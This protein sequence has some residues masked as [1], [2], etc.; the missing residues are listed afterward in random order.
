MC[1]L[2]WFKLWSKDWLGDPELRLCRPASRALLID[3]MAL[4]H[5]AEPYGYLV[6]KSGEPYKPEELCQI[7]HY[8]KRH[9]NAAL[10]ELFKRG[11]VKMDNKGY[12][13]PRMVKDGERR[14]IGRKHGA[15]G[16]SP[17]LITAPGAEH[18]S[19]KPKKPKKPRKPAVVSF[20]YSDQFEEFWQA[21]PRQIAKRKAYDSFN[22]ALLG[23]VKFEKLLSAAQAYARSVEG[24]EMRYVKHPATWLNQ[25]CWDDVLDGVKQKQNSAAKRKAE[26]AQKAKALLDEYVQYVADCADAGTMRG[27][28]IPELIERVGGDVQKRLGKKGLELFKNRTKVF[29]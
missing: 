18:I 12:Y 2:P 16:G 26:Q 1:L 27:E 23:G 4:C 3:I 17:L 14:E 7:L 19:Q 25:G 6:R 8:N 29:L 28:T 9:F 22:K 10:A 21:Y 13:V 24:E 15:R 11:R 20:E 5:L